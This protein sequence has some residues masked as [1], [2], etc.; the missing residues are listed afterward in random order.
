MK[1]VGLL[2][3][4]LGAAAATPGLADPRRLDYLGVNLSGA[5]FGA[6]DGSRHRTL[7]GKLGTDYIFPTR[8]EIDSYADAGFNVARLPFTWERLQP[9]PNGQLDAGY[10]AALDTVVD[11]AAARRMVVILEPAGFGYGYGALIGTGT[12]DSA[13]A[14]L[15]RRVAAHYASRPAVLYG[16]MNEPHDQAPADW[17]HSAQA[18]IDAIRAA[19]SKQEI[20]VPGTDYTAG[21]TWLSRGNAAVFADQITDQAG[22]FAF[23]IHQYNDA[24][25]SGRSAAPVSPTIGVERLERVT[26]WAEAGHHRLFLAEFGAGVGADSIMAMRNQVAFVQ[27]HNGVWQG[28]AIWGGGPWWPPGY[29]LSV[30]PVAGS[31]QLRALHDFLPRASPFS[32]GGRGPG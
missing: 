9:E 21:S 3:L 26:A 11:A 32:A 2:A 31:P 19:G 25:Q 10:L 13:F 28:A 17:L 8:N 20:L 5:E 16:L 29:P 14:D 4:L 6:L 1:R 7:P 27:A 23:E 30:E 12:P 24:D 18:A 22:N 15:W